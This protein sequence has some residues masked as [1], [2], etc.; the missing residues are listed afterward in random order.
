MNLPPLQTEARL[1]SDI[2]ATKTIVIK[3]VGF[4]LCYVPAIIYGVWG[5]QKGTIA[6]MWFGFFA[7]YSLYISSAVN[8][9]VYYLRTN[10]FRSAFKQFLKDPFGSNDFKEKPTDR[11][12]G[13]KQKGE[14]M[15][16]QEDRKRNGYEDERINHNDGNQTRHEYSVQQKNDV[17]G[18]AIENLQIRPYLHESG[19]S[20]DQGETR[21]QSGSAC[22]ERKHCEKIEKRTREESEEVPTECAFRA[23]KLRK[24]NQRSP[25]GNVWVQQIAPLNTTRQPSEAI[26]ATDA[27]CVKNKVILIQRSSATRRNT[28]TTVQEF[29][30]GP[31]RAAWIN[32]EDRLEGQEDQEDEEKKEFNS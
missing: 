26:R 31:K 27:Y 5:H 7:W 20:K 16:R 8:S 25:R 21:V 2:K 22:A 9:I 17:M 28:L 19:K 12:K 32:D 29:P 24:Q 4:F 1:Q 30:T 10:R 11:R 6:D 3:V 14:D 15:S 18:L 23:S 13:E